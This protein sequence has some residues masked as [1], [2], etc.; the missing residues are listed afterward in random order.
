ML[1]S[2]SPLGERARNNRWG[3][4]VGAYVVASTAAAAAVGTAVGAVGSVVPL[5]ATPRGALLAAVVAAAVVCDA[6]GFPL[7]TVHR[8]VNEDWLR[9][10]RG[11]AYGAG[12]GAQLGVGVVT[13][14]T[15][16]TVYAALAGELLAGSALA[17]AAIG[18][19]FGLARAL[20]LP[21]GGRARSFADLASLHRR[22]VGLGSA[23]RRAT[24]TVGA[25]A[26]TVL[27]ATSVGSVR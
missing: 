18:A 4:T 16:A 1:T 21:V 8:Q 19:A 14:V 9:R 13:I 20:P 24:V 17:G 26:V 11:W 5:S 3:V 15:S 7:P 12:F 2:I 6:G 27:V 22:L 25:L 23:G 10:Y